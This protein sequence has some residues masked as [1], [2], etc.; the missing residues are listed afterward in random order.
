MAHFVHHIGGAPLVHGSTAGISQVGTRGRRVY[1]DPARGRAHITEIREAIPGAMATSRTAE[2]F[3]PFE[4]E[5]DIFRKQRTSFTRDEIVDAAAKGLC[6]VLF[7]G[8]PTTLELC[9]LLAEA[10][11]GGDETEIPGLGGG[12][13][14]PLIT[15]PDGGC[16]MGNGGGGGNGRTIGPGT[17]IM[18]RYGAGMEPQIFSRIHRDCLPGMVLGTDNVCYNRRDIK[19]AERKYPRGARPLGTPG[20]M[21]A[22]RKAATFGRRMETTVKRMQKIGVLKKPS[23]PRPKQLVAG[24][25]HKVGVVH[26]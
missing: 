7:A 14:P 9:R 4:I 22:L 2:P 19:N 1:I 17:A 8:S 15:G 18:G 3:N 5:S 20:E 21:S 13:D 11:P 10:I 26:E 23:R 25:G 12:C 6:E 24:V 16:V